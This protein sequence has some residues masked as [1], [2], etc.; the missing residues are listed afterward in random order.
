MKLW[1]MRGHELTDRAERH[2][3]LTDL[4]DNLHE[5]REHE[6]LDLIRKMVEMIDDLEV[7]VA[8]WMAIARAKE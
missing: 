3:L 1:H 2:A 6:L 7:D 5:M 8:D 4:A